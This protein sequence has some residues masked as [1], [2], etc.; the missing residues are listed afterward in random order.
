MPLS[1]NDIQPIKRIAVVTS[2]RADWGLLHPVVSLLATTEG[3]ELNIVA[4]NMHLDARRGH[5]IDEIIADGFTPAATVAVFPHDDTPLSVAKAMGDTINEVAVAFDK[6]NPDLV[7]LLGDRYEMLAMASAVAAMRIPIAHISGGE[8]TEGAIDDSFRHAISKLSS[9]HFATT[10]QHRQRLIAMGE[11][12]ERV[13]NVGALGVSNIMKGE[14]MSRLE[15]ET[16]LGFALGSHPVIV[17]FHPATNDEAD[18]CERF[19][20]L[21]SALESHPEISPLFTYPN[22][23][24]GGNKL[25]AMIESW[26]SQH[27]NAHAVASL[28]RVRYLSALRY[29]EAVIG[30]SSSGIVE[31]PSAGIPTVNIGCRQYRRAA[32]KSVIHCGDTVEEINDA[33]SK[34]L[35]PEFKEIASVADNPY[36][37]PDTP[38]LI[39]DAIVNTPLDKLLPKHFYDINEL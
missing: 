32:G 24:A 13:L 22:N 26:V 15:L 5:T 39:V 35:S 38:K 36:Y 23:D 20:A 18:P 25:I 19:E 34:A 37:Q 16:S 33:I 14:L 6:L 1:H 27:D 21:L 30:N 11:E 9:L 7:L 29:V 10:W 8:I 4:A 17:T 2:T 3:V 28:G 12:P 31:V